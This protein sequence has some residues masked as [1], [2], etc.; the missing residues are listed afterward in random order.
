MDQAL[1]LQAEAAKIGMNVQVKKVTN[2][3]YW[4]AV[5]MKVPFFVSGWNMRPTAN[6]FL[7]LAF[8]STAKWNETA[9]QNE[10]FDELLVKVRSVTDPVLRKQM[11]C[12]MQNMIRDT[13][14]Q[15]ITAHRSYIDGAAD[16]VKGRTAVP[17][18]NFGGSESP[19]YLWR[20]A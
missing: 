10:Q 15:I 12:D 3:G 2:D 20:D 8:A 17:L 11:Y 1:Y 6:I 13:A 16:H 18:N 5:W 4:G 19:P 7:S 9:W 14:G